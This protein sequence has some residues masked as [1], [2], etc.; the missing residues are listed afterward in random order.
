MLRGYG[1]FAYSLAP[2]FVFTC[3]SLHGDKPRGKL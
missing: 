2:V 3:G 1:L